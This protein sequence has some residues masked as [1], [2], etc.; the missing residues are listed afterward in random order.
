MGKSIYVYVKIHK[1]V[2]KELER[3]SGFLTMI[4][5]SQKSG[6]QGRCT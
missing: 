1:G 5:N 3:Y 2:Q 6:G 4:I